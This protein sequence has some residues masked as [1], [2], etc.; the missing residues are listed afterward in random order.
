MALLHHGGPLNSAQASSRYIYPSSLRLSFT[1]LRRALFLSCDS[2]SVGVFL[3]IDHKPLTSRN[4][5]SKMRPVVLTTISEGPEL[6]FEV[7][8]S[9][10]VET[11]VVSRWI[12]DLE[13]E[14][15]KARSKDVL[16]V[17]RDLSHNVRNACAKAG[18]RLRQRVTKKKASQMLDP[19][20]VAVIRGEVQ[21]AHV[22]R[23]R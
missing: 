4:N 1:P 6:R 17:L 8:F 9:T 10:E 11:R 3:H 22:R 5:M 2:Y 15:P 18:K 13:D 12:R 19:A 7:R 23:G 14:V 16:G 20:W 21:E